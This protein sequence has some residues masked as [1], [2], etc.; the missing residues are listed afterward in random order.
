M[1]SAAK[2]ELL[3]VRDESTRLYHGVCSCGWQSAD[4][5]LRMTV[6]RSHDVHTN[7]AVANDSGALEAATLKFLQENS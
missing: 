3:M 2:H 4:Y 6:R 7:S 1:T 5:G